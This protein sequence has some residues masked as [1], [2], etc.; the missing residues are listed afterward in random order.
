MRT[1]L[2]G[3]QILSHFFITRINSAKIWEIS[4]KSSKNLVGLLHEA[5]GAED[6]T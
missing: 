2:V 5:Y 6:G 3:A 1:L 4:G